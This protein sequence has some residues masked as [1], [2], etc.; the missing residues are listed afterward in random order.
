MQNKFKSALLVLLILS[1]SGCDGILVT[2]NRSEHG[3]L[4]S[5]LPTWAGGGVSDRILATGTSHFIWPWQ[6]VYR[7]FTGVRTIRWGDQQGA[8]GDFIEVRTVDGNE[9]RVAVNLQ[10]HIDP[11]MIGHIIQRVGSND[12]EIDQLVEAVGRADIRTHLNVLKT[13]DFSA[14]IGVKDHS[15]MSQRELAFNR[16][17]DALNSRLKNEGIIIDEVLYYR[18]KLERVKSDGTIDS[19]YQNL[20]DEADNIREK[21]DQELL[22]VATVEQEK[23]TEL[24]RAK[25]AVN[26]MIETAKGKKNVL[27]TEGNAYFKV[28]IN[29]ADRIRTS[30]LSEIEGIKSQISAL[31]GPGGR[32]LL[33]LAVVESLLKNNPK[34]VVLNSEGKAG[35]N[36]IDFKKVDTNEL[37]RQA[38]I[39]AGIAEGVKDPV[40]EPLNESP[41]IIPEGTD[42]TA[43]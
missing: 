25:G 16:V 30:G 33:R 4:F 12:T 11:Q 31:S 20:V 23:R 38:G 5:A 43:K 7:I 36:S 13:E 1:L 39:F 10:Y 17:K 14:D 40:K 41:V 29:E 34:F 6:K 28:R 32:S 37:I 15:A 21:T 18:H 9:V 27:E 19:T 26:R 42:Q 35:N 8:S 24:N 3:A 2:I 22:K